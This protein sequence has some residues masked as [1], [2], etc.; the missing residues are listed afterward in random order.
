M[1]I[2][3]TVKSAIIVLSIASI[4]G[5]SVSP[6]SSMSPVSSN[7][8]D[9]D[10]R[11]N[12]L[13]TQ[14]VN[15]GQSSSV[16]ILIPPDASFEGEQYPGSG[17]EIGE[18]VRRS[19]DT[20][21]RTSFLVSYPKEGALI[22]CLER[23]ASFQIEPKV[24]HYE[25]RFTGWSGKPDR[26]ELKLMLSALKNTENQR[27]TYFEARSDVTHS[28]FF[29]WGNAKPTDLLK[30]DFTHAIRKLLREFP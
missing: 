20:L 21:G 13:E 16:C 9:M 11:G 25:D 30:D 5:C 8:K 19:L 29:E 2:R 14:P 18:V 12:Q 23:G 1:L 7:A 10:V 3:C 22:S 4:A 26:I 24:L 27:S 15:E 28:A 17:R 6:V